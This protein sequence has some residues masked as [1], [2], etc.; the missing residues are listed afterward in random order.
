MNQKINNIGNLLLLNNHKKFDQEVYNLLLFC[1]K[2]QVQ[3]S[4]ENYLSK[5]DMDKLD[6]FSLILW[7][8]QSLRSYNHLDDDI[9]EKIHNLFDKNFNASKDFTAQGNWLFRYEFYLFIQKKNLSYVI[10]NFYKRA[11]NFSYEQLDFKK[12]YKKQSSSVKQHS[13]NFYRGMLMYEVG[14]TNIDWPI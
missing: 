2:A 7:F 14:F 12:M 1:E 4:Y 6:D 3:L 5:L 11:S 8:V 9:L 10:D 13:S